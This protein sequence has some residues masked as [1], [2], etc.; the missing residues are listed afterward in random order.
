VAE[1][2]GAEQLDRDLEGGNL[3]GSAVTYTQTA[4][5]ATY[6]L[7]TWGI[8]AQ[9]AGA[10][11]SGDIWREELVIDVQNV[12]CES[13]LENCE[14]IVTFLGTVRHRWAF[15]AARLQAP[16]LTGLTFELN[17]LNGCPVGPQGPGQGSSYNYSLTFT[18]GN[19]DALNPIRL[20]GEALWLPTQRVTGL[21]DVP[22]TFTGTGFE[23]EL[24]TLTCIWW[25]R[26]GQQDQEFLYSV[27]MK[28]QSGLQSNVLTITLTRPPGAN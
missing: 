27:Y 13:G 4:G 10:T 5:E 3:L 23:G 7:V 16:V 26:D 11:L 2:A 25:E 8:D 14:Q 15:E 21:A 22:N 19:G 17:Q 6:D 24:S 1:G 20:T 28:D 12:N 9:A 18:D